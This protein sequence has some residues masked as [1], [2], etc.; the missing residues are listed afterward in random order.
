MSASFENMDVWGDDEATPAPKETAPTPKT[1]AQPA[2]PQAKEEAN[3][4]GE[5]DDKPKAPAAPVVPTAPVVK[6]EAKPEP[7]DEAKPKTES[8][9]VPPSASAQPA[10]ARPA[11]P[12]KK[13]AAH[14]HGPESQAAW[15]AERAHFEALHREK[16]AARRVPMLVLGVVVL[17]LGAG[18]MVYWPKA[19]TPVP[20][21]APP[22][23]EAPMAPASA[24]EAPQEEAPMAPAPEPEEAPAA[25]MAPMAPA[26]EPE[27]APAPPAPPPAE[28]VVP[29][30]PQIPTTPTGDIA[31]LPPLPGGITATGKPEPR[32]V[33]KV[34][35]RPKPAPERKRKEPVV[36]PK[37]E[38]PEDTRTSTWDAAER[39]MEEFLRQQQ[40]NRP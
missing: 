8:K 39:R 37:Y 21:V 2:E 24:P 36:L 27:P 34:E 4:W 32:K 29:E 15:D 33:D 18:A 20:P 23:V 30:P 31:K 6:E 25:P 28:L 12:R 17:A 40:G 22:V 3:A 13:K 14:D 10:V 19:S 5:W 7:K 26:P 35:S 11:T 16:Q 9:T 38:A 1:T